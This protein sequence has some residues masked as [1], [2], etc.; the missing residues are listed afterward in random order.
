[1]SLTSDDVG[2]GDD[3]NHS[4]MIDVLVRLVAAAA[5]AAVAVGDNEA[6]SSRVVAAR[7]HFDEP[8]MRN[9]AFVWSRH[10]VSDDLFFIQVLFSKRCD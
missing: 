3:A 1:M 9:R 10:F 8:P 6:D 7:L 2:C 5:A 4:M